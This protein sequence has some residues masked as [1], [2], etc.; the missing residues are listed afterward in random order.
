MDSNIK[1]RKMESNSNS[2]QLVL[3]ASPGAT[4]IKEDAE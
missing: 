3:E 2:D 4:Q 1:N